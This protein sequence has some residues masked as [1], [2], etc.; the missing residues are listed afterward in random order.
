MS[1]RNE[2]IADLLMGAA[3]ADNH[4]DGR[5]YEIVKSLLAKSM[6][7]EVIPEDMENRIKQFDPSKFDMAGT[8][9]SLRLEDDGQ[10]LQLVEFI[11]AVTEADDV[12]D[13]DE[14]EYLEKVA[15][16]LEL[17][18][19]SYSDMTMEVLSVEN[20]QEVGRNLIK[21]PPIPK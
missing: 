19:Q 7:L 6:N 13:L 10:K 14:N 5:E 15:Q 2:A 3:Y 4:L 20:L 9:E 21:P 1:T 17:P 12:L 8:A 11:A 16:F 18:R